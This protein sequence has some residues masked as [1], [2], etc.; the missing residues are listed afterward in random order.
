MYVIPIH[1]THI[2]NHI[3]AGD[4]SLETLQAVSL[5][6]RACYNAASTLL[7][8]QIVLK[9][10]DATSLKRAVASVTGNKR[11]LKYVRRLELICIPAEQPQSQESPWGN[12]SNFVRRDMKTLDFVP[13]TIGPFLERH[14]AESGL[15][16]STH[17]HRT[18]YAERDWQP[19]ASLIASIVKLTEFH[20]AVANLFPTCLLQAIHDHHPACRLNLWIFPGLYYSLHLGRLS[21]ESLRDSDPYPCSDPFD[22][23]VL[24]SPCLHAIKFFYRS[25]LQE[26]HSDT[27]TRLRFHQYEILPLIAEA[28]NIKHIEL[29]QWPT[30]F[31]GSIVRFPQEWEETILSAKPPLPLKLESPFLRR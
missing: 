7:Y 31:D 17:D 29:R 22:M 4:I 10:S 25:E 8:S 11:K 9:F 23:E 1:L 19:L 18:L 6:N 15:A 16:R 30:L 3:Q 28:P 20:Y 21:F 2:T 5:V 27:H 13:P 14:L 12:M 24:R 26:L